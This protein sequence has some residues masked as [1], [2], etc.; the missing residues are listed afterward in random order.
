MCD[1]TEPLNQIHIEDIGR[2]D[3]FI[4]EEAAGALD[5]GSPNAPRGNLGLGAAPPPLPGEGHLSI[6][7]LN[8]K[9]IEVYAT[10]LAF[11]NNP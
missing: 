9:T 4:V 11:Q 7:C 2:P 6:A 8:G 1:T 10:F 3:G 5:L